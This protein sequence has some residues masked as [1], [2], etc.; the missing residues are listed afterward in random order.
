[1][2]RVAGRHRK[3]HTGLLFEIGEPM[4]VAG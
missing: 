2:K 3:D 1:M 4:A